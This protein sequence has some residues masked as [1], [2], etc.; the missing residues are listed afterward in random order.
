MT[1]GDGGVVGTTG[2]IPGA[3][4]TQ[5][6]I[7]WSSGRYVI[8]VFSQTQGPIPE[9]S[10]TEVTRLARERGCRKLC[11]AEL[12]QP[13]LSLRL[14]PSRVAAG[15][16]YTEHERLPPLFERRE[17]DRNQEAGLLDLVQACCLKQLG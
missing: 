15:R 13:G 11:S 16:A 17:L 12:A 4:G 2:T 10:V 14:E 6:G 1:I 7:T 8:S 3:L 5:T 9:L